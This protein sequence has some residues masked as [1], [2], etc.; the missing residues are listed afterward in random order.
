MHAYMHAY[1]YTQINTLTTT[2]R[3]LFR[4]KIKKLPYPCMHAWVHTCM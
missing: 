4:N 3:N 2:R 1:T